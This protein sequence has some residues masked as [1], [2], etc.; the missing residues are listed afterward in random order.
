MTTWIEDVSS[1]LVANGLGVEAVDLWVGD[2]PDPNDAPGSAM[3]L[4]PYMGVKGQTAYGPHGETILVNDFP[5]FQV[6][7]RDA[8]YE[9]LAPFARAM[10]VYLF[11]TSCNP[12]VFGSSFFRG[13]SASPPGKLGGQDATGRHTVTF[14]VEVDLGH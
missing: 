3:A 10:S 7:C 4:V 13:F 5:R 6:Y 1:L 14:R 9:F 2:L 8:Q 11:F 12:L